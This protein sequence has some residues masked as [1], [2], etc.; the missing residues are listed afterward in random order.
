MD[1]RTATVALNMLPRI[2]PV[3]VKRLLERFGAAEA[4]FSASPRDLESV[5][6]IGSE[7]AKIL[8][9]WRDHVDV[10]NE[11]KNADLRG[12]RIILQSDA[13]FPAPLKALYDCP[14]LLYVWGDLSHRD[15]G[16][17]SIVGTRRCTH[18]G[19][20]TTKKFAYQ[21][22][23]AGL[24]VISGLARGIDTAAHEGALA[25]E[26]RTI[27]VIG[28]GLGQLY[29]PENMALAARIADGGGA[30]VSEFSLTTPPDKK[31]FPQ[32]NRIVAGWCRGLLV[33]ESPGR[34]GSLITANLAGEAGKAVYAVPGQ[35]DRPTSGGCHDLIRDGATLV[36]DAGQIL[37]DFSLLPLDDR[38]A[39][40]PTEKRPE[41]TLDL[42][43][44]QRL[45]Y[46]Q[47]S[48]DESTIDELVEST[49]LPAHVI[50]ANLLALELKALAKSLPG[51]HYVKG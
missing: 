14:L 44:E 48:S 33:V 2:G 37:D 11:L 39:A 4:I 16:G 27:A 13:D 23:N 18:Y 8:T 36:T 3:R 6:G 25:A 15:D 1:T 19:L 12:I 26:G 45:I 31:T 40:A 43:A 32:R 51:S 38:P 20:Q 7:T 24:T 49:S 17:V 29:P 35:I 22:A 47:L 10:D 21:L 30:V 9:S 28:S 34:S 41:P 42:T 5:S 50:S 46:D